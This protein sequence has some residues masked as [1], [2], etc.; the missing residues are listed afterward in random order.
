MSEGADR[1]YGGKGT[2]EIMVLARVIWDCSRGS[3]RS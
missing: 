2:L 1:L 3:S